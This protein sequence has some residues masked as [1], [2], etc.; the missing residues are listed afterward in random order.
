MKQEEKARQRID[1]MLEAAGWKVQ[2]LRGLNLAASLGV[3]VREFSLKSGIADYLL[4]V[5]RKAVGVVEAK[6]EGTSLSDVLEPFAETMNDKFKRWLSGRRDLQKGI[7]QR[8]PCGTN[9]KRG[10]G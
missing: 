8:E 9:R 5:E 3:A 10:I 4:F 6:P 7:F 1:Q 2:D